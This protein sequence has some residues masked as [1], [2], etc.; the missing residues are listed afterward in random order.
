VTGSTTAG[1][2]GTPHL[3]FSRFLAN[4][5]G[6]ELVY[7]TRDAAGTWSVRTVA[8]DLPDSKCNHVPT[9]DGEVCTYDDLDFGPLAVAAS[10]SG[11]VR[12]FYAR[13]REFGSLTAECTGGYPSTPGPPKVPGSAHPASADAG[14]P[15]VFCEWKGQRFMEGELRMGWPDGSSV[16]TALVKQGVIAAAASVKV[17]ASGH[18]HLIH[19]HRPQ[20]TSA[21]SELRYLRLGSAPTP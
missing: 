18:L 11:S 9:Y 3:L 4:N 6:R 14:P 7:A 12:F 20:D 10:G 13:V 1:E 21:P 16:K 17:D 8:T 2:L 5:K 19:H 15:P